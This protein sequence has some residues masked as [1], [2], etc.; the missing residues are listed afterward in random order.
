MQE[1]QAGQNNISFTFFLFFSVTQPF[2]MRRKMFV[3]LVMI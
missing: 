1:E 3:K 2:T